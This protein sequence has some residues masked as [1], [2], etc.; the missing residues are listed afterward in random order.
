[1]K[2]H[3]VNR[4]VAAAVAAEKAAAAAAQ[5]AR[6]AARAARAAAGSGTA[7]TE[8]RSSAERPKN[9]PEPAFGWAG[10]LR[11]LRDRYTSVELQHSIRN[12]RVK[13]GGRKTP[14]DVL[15]A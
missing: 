11:D 13:V 6:A 8:P 2:D 10:A 7:E 15:E 14:A 12:S 4:A 5:A 3:V 1:M 9:H